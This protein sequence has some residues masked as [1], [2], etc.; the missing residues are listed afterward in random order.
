MI[1]M[2]RALMEIVHKLQ[3]KNIGQ[4]KQRNGNSNNRPKRNIRV[5]KNT[6]IKMK[7]TF[8]GLIN[9]LDMAEKRT[10]NLRTCQQKVLQLKSKEEKRLIKNGTKKMEQNI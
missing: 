10:V 5:K 3:K 1:H 2:L 7:N 8:G 6:I 9:R 4:C